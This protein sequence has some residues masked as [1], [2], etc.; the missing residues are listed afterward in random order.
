MEQQI[1][2][3]CNNRG[4][5]TGGLVLPVFLQSRR[6][7]RCLQVRETTSKGWLPESVNFQRV[8]NA[9]VSGL[10]Y[11]SFV[12]VIDQI[13]V[14]IRTFLTFLRD[15]LLYILRPSSGVN[16]VNLYRDDRGITNQFYWR[17]KGQR[18]QTLS[19]TRGDGLRVGVSETKLT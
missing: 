7:K 2:L 1:R 18:V 11:P 16:I 17:T 13:S 12:L 10:Q 6:P 14:G 19:V 4:I 5:F 9:D 3:L 15:I 8:D